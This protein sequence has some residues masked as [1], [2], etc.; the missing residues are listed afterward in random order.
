MG[1]Q[2]LKLEGQDI[3][4]V[5]EEFSMDMQERGGNPEDMPLL[6]SG[7][8]L[9]GLAVMA[10]FRRISSEQPGDAVAQ[11]LKNEEMLLAL[12]ESIPELQRNLMAARCDDPDCEVHGLRG[13]SIH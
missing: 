9:G 13:K 6:L 5:I 7:F 12:M 4:E 8:T 3:D 1:T 10:F 2:Y 11:I